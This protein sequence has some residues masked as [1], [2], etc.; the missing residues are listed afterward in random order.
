M[1]TLPADTAFLS[2][3]LYNI[4]L[5]E[6]MARPVGD[7]HRTPCDSCG[8]RR[9]CQATQL[10][11]NG[12]HRA[13]CHVGTR[14][15]RAG[16]AVYRA[17]DPFRNLYVSRAG[18]CKSIRMHR[19]GHQQITSFHLAGEFM[20]LDAI[21]S[22]RH[23][24]EAIALEDMVLC[25]L[26]YH[27]IQALGDEVVDARRCMERMLSSEIVREANLL[28]LMGHLSAEERL[29]AFLVDLADRYAARGYS[30]TAFHL[31]M[32]REEIGSYLGM[33]LETVSRM[34][35]R[36]QRRGLISL[37]GREVQILDPEALSLA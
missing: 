25:V 30:A 24:T 19:D 17:D 26:P 11:C 3:P 37:H 2:T 8:G 12:T 5:G 29:A 35:S 18:T 23:E 15:L 31:R 21:A 10:G 28:M 33:K 20:G 6:F 1:D 36:L 9:L 27:E 13:D 16:E 22:G 34:F 7:M 4:P 14:K 32:T